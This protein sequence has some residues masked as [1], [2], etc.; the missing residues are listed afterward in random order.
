[1]EAEVRPRLLSLPS[2]SPD[3]LH[4]APRQARAVQRRL[5]RASVKD[6]DRAIVTANGQQIRLPRMQLQ[7]HNAC[8]NACYRDTKGTE[9]NALGDSTTGLAC[10]RPEHKLRVRRALQG[11]SGDQA[12][13]L[14]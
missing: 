7:R 2:N 10:F 8:T 1:M 13:D 5:P 3:R 14:A 4:V 12:G 9:A 6:C 11:K